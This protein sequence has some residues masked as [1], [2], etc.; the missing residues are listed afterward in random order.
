M[1]TIT[2]N[3]DI[4]SYQFHDL[5]NLFELTM[6]MTID[7]IKRAKQKVLYMHPDKSKR[8]PQYFLFYKKAF[9][10]IVGYFEELTKQDA[11]V[12][13]VQSKEDEIQYDPEPHF[14]QKNEAVAHTIRKYQ[15][16]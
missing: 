7:D 6:D 3:L 12:P 5:L 14:I 10:I 2:H 8:P 15:D 16:K 11:K 4:Q 9:E 1:A 13:V